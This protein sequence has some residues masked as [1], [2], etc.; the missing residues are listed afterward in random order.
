MSRIDELIA[1]LCPD[2]VEYKALGDVGVFIR[3]NGLQKSDLIESG[4]PAIHYGQIHTFYGTWTESAKSFVS[5]V[6]AS[7]LRHAEHGDVVIVTTSE[8]D[9]AVAK[10]T[11]WLGNETAA[12]SGDAYIYRHSLEPKY[13]AYFMQT[14]S[15]Q[16][17]KRPLL[18][19]TK[20]R[21][22]SG[23]AL[24][25]IRIPVPPLAIQREIV[26]ILDTFS[27]LEA[28]LEAELEARRQQYMHYRNALLTFDGRRII[29]RVRF[30]N[31]VKISRGGSPRP[32][33]SFIT[34]S[35]DGIPWIKIGDIDAGGKYITQT[36]ERIKPSG[37]MMSRRVRPGDFVLS[38]SMSY[39]RP[40][41]SMIEGCIHDGWLA[42]SDY[43]DSFNSDFL[44]HL[45]RSTSVQAEFSR[46]A[47]AGTVRNLNADIVKAIFVPVPPLAEQ[48]RIASVLDHFDALVNDISIGLPAELAAR[49]TQYE[50]YRD[51]LLTFQ[52]RPA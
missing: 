17:Q 51:R 47:G 30:G 29:P 36:S 6:L 21:R 33:H 24:G 23:N 26:R 2:G 34:D 32:I 42:I 4:A 52:E 7:K 45:L 1:K 19:G 22:I 8:D 48:E 31:L 5:P 20:V 13:I 50:Y 9:E 27:A 15:F 40:Y 38:N 37:V 41:I 49:R 35:D 28:E 11:A 12:V 3:G 16:L 43:A 18:T 39:G 25:K 10:A 44:Y 46:R 14:E